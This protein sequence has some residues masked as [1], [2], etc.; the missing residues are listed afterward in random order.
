MPFFDLTEK[1]RKEQLAISPK[2]SQFQPA[3]VALFLICTSGVV[4]AAD[5]KAA[6]NDRK[7]SLT[8]LH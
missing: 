8:S 3:L 2:R 4:L 5:E 1:D 7:S 6:S